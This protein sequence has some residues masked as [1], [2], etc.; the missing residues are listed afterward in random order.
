M[1]N[2]FGS[3]VFPLVNMDYLGLS[4]YEIEIKRLFSLDRA[5]LINH[6]LGGFHVGADITANVVIS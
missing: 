2:E 1:S 6:P 4:Q 3:K 5:S